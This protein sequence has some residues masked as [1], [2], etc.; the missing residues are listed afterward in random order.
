MAACAGHGTSVKGKEIP[1]ENAAVKL[2]VDVKASG[3]RLITTSELKKSLDEGKKITIIST[4]P[5]AEDKAFGKLPGAL[6][7]PLPKT[8]KELTPA[9]KD[10]LLKIA[11]ADKEKEIVLYCGFVACR[12]STIGA[13]ILVDE[14][15]KNVTKYSAE[16]RPGLKR[17]IQL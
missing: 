3:L 13:K 6:S 2:A 17:V 8:E 10:N 5:A 16:S 11:G 7:A 14:G 9:D 15:Y 4:L 12:R 1:I